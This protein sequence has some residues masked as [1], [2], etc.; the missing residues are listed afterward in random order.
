MHKVRKRLKHD[1]ITMF[2]QKL[3]SSGFYPAQLSMLLSI[4]FPLTSWFITKV[5]LR[6]FHIPTPQ[7]KAERTIKTWMNSSHTCSCSELQ[8]FV[9]KVLQLSSADLRSRSDALH[10]ERAFRAPGESESVVPHCALLGPQT[11]IPHPGAWR[12]YMEPIWARV[13]LSQSFPL[14]HES[15][16]S[17]SAENVGTALTF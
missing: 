12:A 10:E 9:R 2:L 7:L 14:K 16:S 5:P 15:G 6:G 4:L 8:H 13:C 11:Q 1:L 3:R 17:P